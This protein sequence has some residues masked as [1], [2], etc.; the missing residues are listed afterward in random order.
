MSQTFHVSGMTCGHCVG[1][2]TAEI[3]ALA[4][5][6][7]VDVALGD[8]STLTI[9]GAELTSEQVTAALDEAGGYA[10]VSA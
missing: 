6:A 9:E 10:L 5:G 3:T 7:S 8:P 2:V 4:P 1:A